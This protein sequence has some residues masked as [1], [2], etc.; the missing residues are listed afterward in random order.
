[1]D[2][3][4][5]D[6]QNF[7]IIPQ[8]LRE[9]KIPSDLICNKSNL[10]T[11]ND[12]LACIICLNLL[13]NPRSCSNCEQ[14]FCYDCISSS[15]E[16]SNICPYCRDIYYD[17][18]VP[19]KLLN[20][21]NNVAIFCPNNCRTKISYSDLADHLSRCQFTNLKT[22]C[23]LCN[24]EILDTNTLNNTKS[25]FLAC[26]ELVITCDQ[27]GCKAMFKRKM[28]NKHLE[29]CDYVIVKCEYCE[30]SYTSLKFSSHNRKECSV[31]I[32]NFYISNNYSL[33]I[34]I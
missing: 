31:N 2:P 24:A 14:M 4:D 25:H 9:Y 13:F 34:I 18:K 3:N 33:F 10:S 5:L 17:T 1:M 32:K 26:E 29:E 11:V 19:R 30:V 8:N 6:I 12:E 7:T 23:N 28:K 16:R 21:L 22:N 27:V 20:L 15:L